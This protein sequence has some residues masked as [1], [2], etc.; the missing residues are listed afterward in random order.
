[1]KLI[2]AA[3]LTVCL[4]TPAI[5]AISISKTLNAVAAMQLVERGKLRLQ[6][7]IRMHLDGLNAE[8]NKELGDSFSRS[9]LF[10]CIHCGLLN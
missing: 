1:M 6:D 9:S 5:S 7:D 2:I 4:L 10:F 3:V 8:K